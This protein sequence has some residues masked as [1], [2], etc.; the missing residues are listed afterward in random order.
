MHFSVGIVTFLSTIGIYV[1][2][3]TG[4]CFL[5]AWYNRFSFHMRLFPLTIISEHVRKN[6][7]EIEKGTLQSNE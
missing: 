1:L 3:K 2:V 7:L 6:E 5:Q 4:V